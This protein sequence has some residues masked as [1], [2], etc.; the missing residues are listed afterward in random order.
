MLLLPAEGAGKV[1]PGQKVNI[2]LDNYP[3]M[4]YGMLEG[5]ISHISEIPDEE[6]TMQQ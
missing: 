2:R 5:V 3:Y 6:F 1:E 4:E